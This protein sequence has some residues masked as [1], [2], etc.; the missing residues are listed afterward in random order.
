MLRLLLISSAIAVTAVTAAASPDPIAQPWTIAG[1]LGYGWSGRDGSGLEPKF[2]MDGLALAYRLSPRWELAGELRS[3][4]QILVDGSRGDR[5]LTLGAAL[6]RFHTNPAEAWEFEFEAGAAALQLASSSGPAPS[7]T[8]GAAGGM[9][10]ERHA[11]P[12]AIGL[13]DLVYVGRVPEAAAPIARPLAATP[14]PS[15]PSTGDAPH[16]FGYS[17]LALFVSYRF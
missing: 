6:I 11:G 17:T 15:S 5:S 9:I 1:T 4:R 16:G 13:E 10:L 12:F 2:D 3:G 7:T 8:A 14:A